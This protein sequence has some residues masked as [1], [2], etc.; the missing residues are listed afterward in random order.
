MSGSLFNITYEMGYNFRGIRGAC[1][2]D[3]GPHRGVFR[4]V[5]E[6]AAE[7]QFL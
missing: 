5:L 6:T 4:C 3:P 1:P 2:V 7:K